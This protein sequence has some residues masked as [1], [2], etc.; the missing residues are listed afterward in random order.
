MV[1]PKNERELL[2]LEQKEEKTKGLNFLK[3][4]EKKEEPIEKKSKKKK[5]KEKKSKQKGKQKKE[6]LTAAE[7]ELK[8]KIPVFYLVDERYTSKMK[9]NKKLFKI[10]KHEYSALK[11]A[12]R[13]VKALKNN[14]FSDEVLKKNQ[15]FQT[16]ELVSDLEFNE[17]L[18]KEVFF[19]YLSISDA[20]ERF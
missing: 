17:I 13:G 2:S 18:E 7:K 15:K 4:K 11:I 10:S 19:G 16:V 8:D 20:L 6:E 3:K 9:F 14:I 12:I 5:P 1:F